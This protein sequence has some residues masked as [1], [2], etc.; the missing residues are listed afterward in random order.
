MT[1][2]LDQIPHRLR[3]IITDFASSEGREKLE[4]LLQ[5]AEELPPLPDWLSDK[6]TMNQV[7][8]CM[9]PVFLHAA[10]QNW[11]M[12]FHFDVPRSSPTVR[13]FATIL[14]EGLD[15]LTP[16]EVL[17]VPGD[18]LE[19]MGLQEVLTYQRMNGIT[20]ML[21]HMKQLA[22]REIESS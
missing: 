16:E 1:S 12:T 5:Y 9:T 4:L 18:C 21:A 11:K 19:Q 10:Q 17:A 22:L 6:S 7:E 14:K 3:E 8:E 13:G 20:A 2:R 15:D